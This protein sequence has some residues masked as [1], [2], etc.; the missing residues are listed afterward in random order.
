VPKIY[1]NSPIQASNADIPFLVNACIIGQPPKEITLSDE[2]TFT[3]SDTHLHFA[4]Q[5]NG[6]IW[7]LLDKPDRTSE[8]NK[9]MLDYAHASL[10][11]WHV[12]GTAIHHQRGEWMIARD[13]FFADFNGGAWYG[14]K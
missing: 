10:A 12:A 2:K 3:E 1:S 4:K 9:M 5:Y 13:I 8:E 7:E 11:H 14:V 6:R